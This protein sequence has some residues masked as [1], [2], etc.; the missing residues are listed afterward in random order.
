MELR[1][2][3]IILI[4]TIF[5]ISG[6]PAA[7]SP[8]R[9]L[10]ATTTE[11]VPEYAFYLC[12]EVTNRIYNNSLKNQNSA[13]YK[14]M[15]AD[16]S[17][18]LE[19][20]YNCTECGTYGAYR[21]I[22]EMTFSNGSVIANCT[23]V[24]QTVYINAVLVKSL[25]GFKLPANNMI[26]GLNISREYTQDK[27]TP[28][29]AAVPTTTTPLPTTTRTTRPATTTT[30][31][32]TTTA[33]SKP[34]NNTTTSSAP[35]STTTA[36]PNTTTTTQPASNSITSPTIPNNTTKPFSNTTTS[37][38]SIT[39]PSTP[40]NTSKTTITSSSTLRNTTTPTPTSNSTFNST[41]KTRKTEAVRIPTTASPVSPGG[42]YYYRGVP[43]WAIALLVLACIILLL[44][45]ILLI[46]TLIRCC[47]WDPERD[48]EPEP[49]P[50]L[51]EQHTPYE[52]KTFKE[53][54]STP[55]YSPQTPQKSPIPA[56]PYE[57]PTKPRVNRTGMYVVNP[58]S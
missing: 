1:L 47:C 49:L 5:M 23:I 6:S 41:T 11:T 39:S 42:A 31:Q 16:I 26:N 21:G 48:P 36:H 10:E 50:P 30:T 9:A 4:F 12:I 17:G 27:V 46:I 32:N 45:I 22:A 28:V 33:T 35:S 40:N 57:D 18:V 24:F 53:P 43:G 58:E 44:L 14:A 51:P 56:S 7:A 52:R 29:P 8:A 55:S 54:L 20:I 34:P 3:W 19:V 2:S 15:Y 13:D 25:F 37:H 38:T